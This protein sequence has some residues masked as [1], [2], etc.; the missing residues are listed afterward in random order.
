MFFAFTTD[1][2]SSDAHSVL[3]SCGEEVDITF[4]EDGQLIAPVVEVPG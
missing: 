1:R 2:R 3:P 4:A